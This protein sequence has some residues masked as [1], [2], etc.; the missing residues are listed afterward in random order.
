MN[1]QTEV[2]QI[3]KSLRWL[4][5]AV[6]CLVA[7]SV[8]QMGAWLLPLV[9]PDFYMR[10]VTASSGVAKQALEPWEGLSFDEKVKR[11][12]M[13]LITEYRRD[14]DKLR[15]IIKEIP[16]RV[17]GTQF[18]YAL[19]EE[20]PPSTVTPKENTTYGEGDLVLL[21]GSPAT[22]RESY[23]IYNGS[24]PGLADLPLS[25]VREIIALDK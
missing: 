5:F 10:R 11:S 4:T 20:Y 3:A 21:Q 17:P 13:V 7:V 12:S 9:A 15:A 24:I 25:K 22:R 14:G 19:G 23:S 2:Q 6:W 1:E 8:V 16:K 18:H